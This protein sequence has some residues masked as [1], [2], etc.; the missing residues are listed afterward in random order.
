MSNKK[1]ISTIENVIQTKGLV[2]NA[3]ATDFFSRFKDLESF[4]IEEFKRAIK[5]GYI[6]SSTTLRRNI[7]RTIKL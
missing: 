5:C 2:K 3:S 7:K 1:L 4:K 6:Q